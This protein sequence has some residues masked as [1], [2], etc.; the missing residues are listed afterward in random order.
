MQLLG[1]AAH[2]KGFFEDYGR[3]SFLQ[4][5]SA[6][7]IDAAST[8][9]ALLVMGF[10]YYWVVLA[11]TALVQAARKRKLTYT[12]TWWSTIYP[13]GKSAKLHSPQPTFSLWKPWTRPPLY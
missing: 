6:A 3:G 4:G 2:G 13:F 5:S 11:L 10:E 1:T 9:I 7:G 12:L 8:L